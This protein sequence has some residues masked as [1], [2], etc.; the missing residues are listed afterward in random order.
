MPD[1]TYPSATWAELA[2]Q[3]A[4][5]WIAH[6]GGRWLAPENTIEAF[7]MAAELGI[8]AIE[9]DVY[10][11]Q[12]GGLVVMHDSTATH[13]SNLTG[14]T[15]GLTTPAVLR[16]RVDAGT[17]FC[18]TWPNDLHIPLFVDVLAEIGGT[19]PLVVHCNNAGSGAAAVAE[20]LRHERADSVLI[21]AWNEAELAAARAAGIPTILLDEDGVLSG[22]TY[23]GLLAAGTEYIGL[24]PA[25]TPAASIQAAAAAG[26]KVIVYTVNR[27]SDYAALPADGSVW[28]VISDDPWY[29]RAPGPMRTRDIYSAQT[30]YHGMLGIVSGDEDRGFFQ[31][32]N[33][34]GLDASGTRHDDNSSYLGV[35]QGYLGPLPAAFTVDFDFVLDAADSGAASLQLQLTVGDDEY[36]D[37]VDKLGGA[38]TPGYNILMRSNGGLDIYRTHG[39]TA[40][41]TKLGGV[42]TT[43][44]VPGVTNHLRVQVTASQITVTRTNVA[45]PNAVTVTDSSFRGGM[46]PHLGVRSVK[47]R[48]ANLIVS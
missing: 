9:I 4:P 36:D 42:A 14:S 37:D 21:M 48:W 6:R 24:N 26:L 19:V 32:P 41:A 1:P 27:R 18:N 5:R 44:L 31:G 13:T 33:Q 3:P 47:A 2:E 15:G 20:I 46:Y 12:D 22:Q 38:R 29:V 8:D 11:L 16:G 25:L 17:W 28:A 45:T 23:A 30:Y 10:R 39:G 40:P 35:M 34:F 7:R 43:A